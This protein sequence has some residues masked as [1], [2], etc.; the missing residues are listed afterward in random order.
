MLYTIGSC[1]HCNRQCDQKDYAYLIHSCSMN[2]FFCQ[3]SVKLFRDSGLLIKAFD[4]A[5]HDQM[6]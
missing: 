6:L 1:L 5:M 4:S 2:I 3:N